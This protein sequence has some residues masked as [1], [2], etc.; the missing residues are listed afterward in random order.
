MNER[1]KKMIDNKIWT[2]LEAADTQ[3]LKN[4]SRT[5]QQILSEREEIDAIRRFLGA[6]R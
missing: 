2:Y 5:I 1:T 4:M 3:Q 6:T